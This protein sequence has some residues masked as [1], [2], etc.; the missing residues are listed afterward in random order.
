M[1]CFPM[2]RTARQTAPW[3]SYL[4]GKG[5]ANIFP[6]LQLGFKEYASTIRCTFAMIE[7]ISYYKST[8]S[9]VFVVFPDTTK[10]FDHINFCTI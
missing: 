1:P 2:V 9:D 3:F 6:H 7:V 10:A 4:N 5:E 8:G